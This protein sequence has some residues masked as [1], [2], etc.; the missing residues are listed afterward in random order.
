MRSGQITHLF[1]KPGHGEKMR[2]VQDV[3]A[4]KDMGFENDQSFGKKTR[5][6]LLVDRETLNEFGLK[7]GEIRENMVVEDLS[8]S[9]LATG[10]HL[11]AGE[12]KLEITGD[13]APCDYLNT[14]KPGLMEEIRGRRGMFAMVL[15]G[16]MIKVKTGISIVE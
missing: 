16:G 3:K 14:I 2:S 1:I 4:V 10:T 12:V 9:G 15:E 13:C 11:S 5:Q 6:I 8:V 7:P